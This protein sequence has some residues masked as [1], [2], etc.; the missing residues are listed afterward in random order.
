MNINN[1][2]CPGG[3]DSQ[4]GSAA[5][6]RYPGCHITDCGKIPDVLLQLDSNPGPYL[7][8]IWNSHQ[9]EVPMAKYVWDHIQESKIKITDAWPKRIKFWYVRRSGLTTTYHKIGSVTVAKTQCSGFL[10]KQGAELVACPLTTIAHEQYR[11]GAAWDG[12]LV[13]PGQGEDENGYEVADKETANPNNF[14]S[15]IRLVPQRAFPMSGMVIKS[16]ITGVS[17]PSFGLSLDETVQSFF[18]QMLDSV[19]DLNNIPKPIFV[20]DRTAR[21]GLLFEGKPLI[22]GDLLDAE[23]LERGNVIVYEDVGG[24]TQHYTEELKTLFMREFP[25]LQREEFIL[26]H[27]VGTCLFACPLLGLYTHGYK[28][29]TV[30]PVVRFF[31]HKLFQLWYDRDLICTDLQ[32]KFFERHEDSWLE[33]GAEFIRFENI[34]PT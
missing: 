4:T 14:T 5:F 23:E 25:D 16:W 17:M 15:F 29:D 8:P 7:I 28:V 1:I 19:L 33:K 30:E 27:G 2:F 6:E 9:G 10:A 24:M 11:Q 32:T 12:V 26:H 21:V 20:F 31:I 18:E 13:A 3:V 34:V 22:S